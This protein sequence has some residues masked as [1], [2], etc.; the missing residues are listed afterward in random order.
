MP[1]NYYFKE[2]RANI[3]DKNYAF[4]VEIVNVYVNASDETD[5]HLENVLT[6][7]KYFSNRDAAERFTGSKE[8]KSI[9]K[10]D[11]KETR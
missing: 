5:I 2:K 10:I 9:L 11:I 7:G 3:L 4:I 6:F 8:V 1:I